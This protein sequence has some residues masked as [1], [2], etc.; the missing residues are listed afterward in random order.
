MNKLKQRLLSLFVAA[1][2]VC[3][4]LP[5]NAFAADDDG[6]V[7]KIGD[8]EYETLD[9]AVAAAADG[10]TIELLNNATTEGLN[11]S[12]NLTIQ[13]AEGVTTKPT[14]NFTKHGIALWGK[15]L[16]FKDV[17]V[18]MTGIGSTP[19]TAEW[20]WMTICASKNASLSLDNTTMT[21]D[22]ANA[23]NK[24][25]IYF[26]SNNKLN[27]SNGSNLTIRNY[28]QDALEW[29]GGD[30]G[31]NVNITNSTF[32][33]DHNR[34][35]F[36]GT[37]YA[38]ITN[39]NVK[40]T[41]STG[42]GSNGS[43]F[44][45]NNSTVNFNN[46]GSHGLSAGILKVTDSTINATD[47]GLTGVIF[48]NKGEFKNSAITI[49]GTKGKSY[50]N[51]GM[52]LYTANS[53]ATIDK[54]T[55]LTISDNLVTGLFMD[56]STNLTIEEGANILITRNHAKQANC[57]SKQDLAQKGGGI[58][59]RSG[60]SATL[61]A[62]T[63]IYNNHALL[64]GDDVYVEDATGSLTFG[65]T[66]AD[67]KLDGDPD[68]ESAIDGWY[69]D[70]EN[71]RWDD[72]LHDEADKAKD[73]PHVVVFDQFGEN[74]L[75]TIGVKALK[76]AHGLGGSLTVRKGVI[77][78]NPDTNKEF[79]FTVAFTNGDSTS[80]KLKDGESQTFENLPIGTTY[81][82]TE[83]DAQGY[84]TNYLDSRTGT[85]GE[86]NLNPTATVVNVKDLDNSALFI[87]KTV[88][89]RKN[90]TTSYAFTVTFANNATGTIRYTGSERTQTFNSGNPVTL[91][92]GE[93]AVITG[94]PANTEYEIAEEKY[95][96]TTT[97]V[98]T[99]VSNPEGKP[100]EGR[101]AT[102]TIAKDTVVGVHFTNSYSSGTVVVP[103]NPTTETVKLH[104]ESNGG[105]K[106]D[107]ETY[108]KGVTATLDKVPTRVGYQFTGWYADKDLTQKITSIKMDSDK[109]VYAG[110][111]IA[112]VPGM[113]NGDDHF[114]YVVG[115]PDGTVK[116]SANVSR[117]ETA[118]IFFRLLNPSVRESNLTSKNTFSDV[119]AGTWC[120]TSIATMQKLGIIAGRD[121]NKFE[122]DAP[123]TRAEFAAI[124][125]RFDT[126]LTNGASNFPDIKGHWAEKEIE[127]AASLGWISGGDDGK[128]YPDKNISR[129]E[130]MSI[131]NR[132]LCRLPEN[133]SDLLSGMNVWPDNKPGTW[134][135]LAVQEATNSHD[136]VHKGEIYEKWTKMTE[137]PDWFQYS[138]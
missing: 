57:S 132:V 83:T 24:H 44:I 59:V 30:G 116:P 64:A 40:V 22:G 61:S 73:D 75:A 76:A 70:A 100:S 68:C 138:H 113:L 101:K 126:G 84:T 26:C 12:K 29:D 2:M 69:D 72:P 18:T 93:S 36:T 11:L 92:S 96:C 87:S 5:V 80:F 129:A 47:N 13:A 66:G 85:I 21:M 128:F 53:S 117:A 19:Y 74:G 114:A 34:S 91:K 99:G 43:H 33:S 25:A 46:N 1:L 136:C 7:A 127:R 124:C 103:P 52:R 32:I 105:T 125:A 122:P 108:T 77:A 78:D 94:L 20:N 65:E 95:N 134:Y 31:Y 54:D 48:N 137:D 130:A 15:A 6:N 8:T 131:I 42:N 107:D 98:T 97:Y 17:N 106:Y 14:I 110:W 27:L 79:D 10:A 39:S 112:T 56:A 109:T 55:T 123:I 50:W 115:Y 89:G 71:L 45:I 121:N 67:W 118:A 58:V 16:T 49:T 23:G 4:I 51:A 60:A 133:E 120:N 9:A 88:N 102:G 104:Y 38:T 82:V 28:Q 119:K 62:S 63:Q 86:N 111:R 3:S 37:F 35:G 81:T 41:N 135:Y 90:D